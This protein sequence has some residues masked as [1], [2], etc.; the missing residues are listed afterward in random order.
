MRKLYFGF[1][2]L[3]A[4]IAAPAFAATVA[5]AHAPALSAPGDKRIDIVVA[6]IIVDDSIKNRLP[7]AFS[8]TT[9]RR[10]IEAAFE[11]TQLFIVGARDRHELDAVLDEIVVS[12]RRPGRIV[13]AQFV[14]VATVESVSIGER[15]RQ[16]PRNLRQ[17]LLSTQGAMAVRITFLDASNASV[18]TRMSV[19]CQWSDRER[20]V[21][22]I[23]DG[24]FP[25]HAE[26]SPDDFVALSKVVGHDVSTRA[27]EQFFPVRVVQRIDD[28]V[29]LGRGEDSGY[30]VGQ[31]LRV[32]KPGPELRDPSTG[33]SLGE[34][35]VEIAELKVVEVRPR[36]TIA[37]IV[38]SKEEVM[39]GAI[40]RDALPA[41]PVSF[42]P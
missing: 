35:D 28:Q 23:N 42:D 13:G 10:E 6:P 12:H 26:A 5:A 32:F 1:Q 14:V 11:S 22:P 18:K 21:D 37:K 25:S 24:A 39:A 34:A 4:L 16:A 9:L 33:L 30:R 3:C 29:F 7:P 41:E 17:D 8:A 40:V 15:R 36:L 31:L 19:D 38:S 2:F 20:L 27:L